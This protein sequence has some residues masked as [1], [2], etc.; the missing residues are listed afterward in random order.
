MSKQQLLYDDVQVG[1]TLPPLVKP[2]PHP[3]TTVQYG[4]EP[5]GFL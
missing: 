4:C 2:P 1:D 5:R 3:S